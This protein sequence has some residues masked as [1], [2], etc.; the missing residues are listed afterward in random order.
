MRAT[1]E[2]LAAFAATLFAG[3]ALYI[4]IAEHPARMR[5][6][7]HQAILQWT[8]SYR[9]ATL[10]QAPLALTSLLAGAL[11]WFCGAGTAWLWSALLIGAVVPFT[12]IVVMATNRQLLDPQLRPEPAHVQA[13]LRR[14]NRL[15]AVRTACS[16][17]AALSYLWLLQRGG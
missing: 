5:L 7:T 16:L 11:A 10:L 4:N 14:W 15:H 2:L 9:R 3:A 12:F 1:V 8:E 17:T 13:L 6:D